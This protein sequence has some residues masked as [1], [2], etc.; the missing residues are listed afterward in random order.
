MSGDE[1]SSVET[2]LGAAD[3]AAAQVCYVY[4][5]HPAHETSLRLS[6]NS[7]PS[8]LAPAPAHPIARPLAS[9]LSFRREPTEPTEPTGQAEEE[10]VQR[11]T[12]VKRPGPEGGDVMSTLEVCICGQTA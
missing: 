8:P 1:T 12:L 9:S 11:D 6:L 4:V 7:A 5:H 3:G 10:L 2:S